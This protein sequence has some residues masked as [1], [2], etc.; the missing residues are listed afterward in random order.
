MSRGAELGGLCRGEGESSEH[1]T[2]Q[3]WDERV[4]CRIYHVGDGEDVVLDEDLGR[5]GGDEGGGGGKTCFD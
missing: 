3:V 1:K 4:G 2:F 5:G